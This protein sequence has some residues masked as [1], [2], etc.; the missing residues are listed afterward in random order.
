[1]WEDIVA[2]MRAIDK[3]CHTEHPNV[4]KVLRHWCE[5]W[6]DVPTYL[7]QMELCGSD[8]DT[9]LKQQRDIGYLLTYSDVSQI[10]RS[11]TAG[12]EFIHSLD[13]VHRDLKPKNGLHPIKSSDVLR[14]LTEN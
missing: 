2:E 6:D 8:L 3:I 13:E 14:S 5:C 1:M 10:G 9:F 7:V 4:V 11:I 12:L